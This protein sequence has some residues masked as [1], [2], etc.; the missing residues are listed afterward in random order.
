MAFV[1]PKMIQ[2][3]KRKDTLKKNKNKAR[4]SEILRKLRDK[5]FAD[6]ER[7][8]LE[9]ILRKERKDKKKPDIVTRKRGKN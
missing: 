7:K 9:Q 5:K 3:R 4:A 1:T 8:M 2:E 6:E